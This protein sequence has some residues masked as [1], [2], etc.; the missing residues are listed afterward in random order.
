MLLQRGQHLLGHLLLGPSG[1]VHGSNN[2]VLSRWKV[3]LSSFLVIFVD[4]THQEAYIQLLT[5][6]QELIDSLLR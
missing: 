2:I 6:I 5:E 3:K 1:G 4:I